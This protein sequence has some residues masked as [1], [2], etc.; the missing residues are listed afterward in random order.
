MRSFCSIKISSEHHI[1]RKV[2]STSER[3][4]FSNESVSLL[5]REGSCSSFSELYICIYIEI[6]SLKKVF[7]FFKRSSTFDPLSITVTGILY[8]ERRCL[9]I[10]A[11]TKT[12]PTQTEGF[13]FSES[14]HR[15]LLYK[16]A[17]IFDPFTSFSLKFPST[18]TW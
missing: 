17:A 5:H 16:K 18:R 14:A 7:D 12:Q 1:P 8:L 2:F 9:R 11:G 13:L 6:A 3:V 10:F 15:I 4:Y